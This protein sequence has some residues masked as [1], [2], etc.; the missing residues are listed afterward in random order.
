MPFLLMTIAVWGQ[1]PMGQDTLYGNE[2]IDYDKTYLKISV[3]EEGIYKIAISDLQE[4]GF[5]IEQV[6]GA[7]LQL[8]HHGQM[9][10]LYVANAGP[11]SAEDDILFYGEPNRSHLDQYLFENDL[12]DMLNPGFSLVNDTAAYFLTRAQ[13]GGLRYNIVDNN[14]GIAGQDEAFYRH[15]VVSRQTNTFVKR[16][17]GVGSMS[18]FSAGEGFAGSASVNGNISLGAEGHSTMGPDAE[19]VVR[20]GTNNSRDHDLVYSFNGTQID[21]KTFNN[22]R[23]LSDTFAISATDLTENN[24]FNFNRQGAANNR[25]FPA[26]FALTYSR[27]FDWTFEG[28]H[29][30]RLEGH[31]NKRMTWTGYDGAEAWLFDPAGRQVIMASPSGDELTIGLNVSAD[32]VLALGSP[33]A[34]KSPARMTVKTFTPFHT[35]A[36]DYIMLY[37]PDLRQNSMGQDILQ[38]YADYRSSTGYQVVLVDV[39]ELYDQFA[40]GVDRHFIALR[41]FAHHRKKVQPTTEMLYIIGKGREFR[42]LRTSNQVASAEGSFYIPTFGA[43]GADQLL[44]CRNHEVSPILA[45]GRIPVQ[46]GDDLDLYFNKVRDYEQAQA[47]PIEEN[48]RRWMK[49]VLH[50]SGGNN[51]AEQSQLRG[52]MS[53]V[54]RELENNEFAADIFSFGKQT[55]EPTQGSVPD[56]IYGLINDGLSLIGFLGHSGSTTI[57]YDIETFSLYSNKDKYPFFLALGCSV[58]NIHIAGQSYGE[59]F[60]NVEDIGSIMFFASSGLG[61]PSILES[62]AR[63]M[64]QRF[65]SEYG[66]AFGTIVKNVHNHFRNTNNRFF[67]ESLEQH[68]LNGDPALKLNTQEGPDYTFDVN[69]VQTVP[70]RVNTQLDSFELSVNI[71]NIG[72]NSGDTVEIRVTREFP[73]NKRDTLPILSIEANQFAN[74]LSIKLPVLPEISIGLNRVYIEIDPLGK[75]DEK[76]VPSALSNNILV[77]AQ[78]QQGFTFNVFS[79]SAE[80]IYPS[81]FSVINESPLTLRAY[82]YDLF[83]EESKFI[84]QIDTSHLF[85]SPMLV[86]ET[87]TESG[88]ILSWMPAITLLD[89]TTYYWRVSSDSISPEQ[90]FNWVS[91]NFTFVQKTLETNHW[92]QFHK[93]QFQLGNIA[94]IDI[95]ND[96]VWRYQGLGRSYSIRNMTFRDNANP[97]G[98][99]EGGSFGSFFPWNVL[100]EGICV[101]TIDP[102]TGFRWRNEAGGQYGSINTT[103]GLLISFPYITKEKSYRESLI[104]LLNDTIVDGQV[105]MVYSIQ[106]TES[107]TYAPEEWALDS[108]DNN[109]LNL[110]NI[111]EKEGF[112]NIR[113]LESLGSVP[114]ALAYKKGEGIIDYQIGEHIGDTVFISV[115]EPE[116]ITEGQYSWN[117]PPIIDSVSEVSWLFKVPDRGQDFQLKTSLNRT[118]DISEVQIFEEENELVFTNNVEVPI[119]EG[120]RALNFESSNEERFSHQLK[121]WSV[122]ANPLPDLLINPKEHFN[123]TGDSIQQG[124]QFEF[125]VGLVSLYD[126][127]MDS[128]EVVITLLLS[129]S[130]SITDTIRLESVQQ[131][132]VQP[133]RFSTETTDLKPGEWLVRIN[134]NPSRS[135]MESNFQN[136]T[137]EFRLVI[138]GDETNPLLSIYF[139]GREIMDGDL[140]SAKPEIRLFLKDEN[141]YRLI[142]DT[143]SFT[144]DLLKPQSSSW[145]RIHFNLGELEFF[146]ATTTK[147]EAEVVFRPDLINDGEYILRVQGRDASGNTSGSR[148]LQKRFQVI[149]KQMISSIVNYP[150]PFS[151]STRFVYTLTGVESP[152]H[153]K[154]QIFSVSGQLVKEISHYEI[155]PLKVGTHVTDYVW[156]GTDMYGQ[157]LA[158][159]IYLYRLQTE[160]DDEEQVEHFETRLDDFVTNGWSKMVILR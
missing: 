100:H 11:L 124:E 81:R 82:T 122:S 68:T 83:A 30:F 56:S 112:Y 111:L 2:W 141:P 79:L 19:L 35:E 113:D 50:L 42:N 44:V 158:N 71:I 139:D 45:I 120:V 99:Y 76:P 147:N 59:R 102:E 67:Q 110:F 87:L 28:F 49:R 130:E 148:P 33:S 108:V 150:N 96:G 7:Q 32:H 29:S 143:S 12:D 137:S 85:D 97:R 153:Y 104:S 4:A 101:V 107:S 117:F 95:G 119:G 136:N 52:I 126:D 17:N 46:S 146:P 154:I 149:N 118:T 27:Q 123:T 75:L 60:V 115:F 78:G 156:D 66:E 151:T 116:R 61:Y 80:P 65:G 9:V 128:V 138:I 36:G 142:E 93:G 133:I 58:G 23:F 15:T 103:N 155:G 114:F 39:L 90:G 135:I 131:N 92:G 20:M 48:D 77:D 38:E 10:P 72:K 127:V 13:G 159:G 37:H 41:N 70:S 145:E 140:V 69:S 73:S 1:M 22:F 74:P 53:R 51:A 21:R 8:F 88:G 5:P 14:P 34:F 121:Y 24:T 144:I 86:E 89:S 43:P 18:R 26:Y 132:M 106:R 31:G 57:D 129:Q 105:V 84:F 64:Y 125:E 98:F 16:P 25:Y 63:D 109:G 40:Y 160:N 152:D 91:S 62:Y 47:F 157:N 55:T 94:N 3:A 54:G 6:T 134:I